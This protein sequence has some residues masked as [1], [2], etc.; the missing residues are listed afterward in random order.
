[1]I[2]EERNLIAST[3]VVRRGSLADH[4]RAAEEERRD[5]EGVA[6]NSSI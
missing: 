4:I 6:F 2:D 1:M 5:R 3:R